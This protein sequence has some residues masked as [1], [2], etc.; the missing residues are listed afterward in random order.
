MNARRAASIELWLGFE[1]QAEIERLDSLSPVVSSFFIA[2]LTVDCPTVS[3]LV[4]LEMT[5]DSVQSTSTSSTST[6]VKQPLIDSQSIAQPEKQLLSAMSDVKSADDIQT[7]PTTSSAKPHSTQVP[8]FIDLAPD[9]SQSPAELTLLIR[10][11]YQLAT[12]SPHTSPQVSLAAVQLLQ[13]HT[14]A[15]QEIRRQEQLMLG[16][17]RL[18]R[19]E[20]LRRM[21]EPPR[22][23]TGQESEI[24]LAALEA[25][26]AELGRLRLTCVHAA[27]VTGELLFGLDKHIIT[28]RAASALGSKLDSGGNCHMVLRTKLEAGPGGMQSVRNPLIMHSKAA[29]PKGIA[30]P[31]RHATL[32]LLL[33]H[34]DTKL[35]KGEFVLTFESEDGEAESED[36]GF[37]FLA[38]RVSS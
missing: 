27:Y 5:S 36:S 25:Q 34:N 17:W 31:A 9:L 20:A 15:T 11:L 14:A 33:N 24:E 19:P 35:M 7:T 26:T 12:A 23:L 18:L 10:D 13:R 2:T 32:E 3:L 4:C 29:A 30:Q 37:K 21:R 22:K 16:E 38:V 6:H 1:R 8:S 28:G